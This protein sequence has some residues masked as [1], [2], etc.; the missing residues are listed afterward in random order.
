MFSVSQQTIIT[1]ST[2]FVVTRLRLGN[3]PTMPC[4]GHFMA[5][6]SVTSQSAEWRFRLDSKNRKSHDFKCLISNKSKIKVSSTTYYISYRY[7]KLLICSIKIPFCPRS[8]TK[9]NKQNVSLRTL[10]NTV[11]NE[12]S[13]RRLYD[14][15]QDYLFICSTML[16]TILQTLSKTTNINICGPLNISSCLQ[17]DKFN[18]AENN[19]RTGL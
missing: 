1:T 14:G 13:T 17:L 19:E 9:Y 4:S 3:A 12:K 2:N 16:D 5:L 8:L 15:F 18:K 10:D 7:Y 11:D 6:H